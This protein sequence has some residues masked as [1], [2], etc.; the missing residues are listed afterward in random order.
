M[1]RSVILAPSAGLS[2]LEEVIRIIEE[3]RLT[4]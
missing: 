4:K 3:D 1:V 2:P